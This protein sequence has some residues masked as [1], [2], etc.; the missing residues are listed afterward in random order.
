LLKRKL[1][2]VAG[3]AFAA[4]LVL[5][6]AT[7]G[8]A[9]ATTHRVTNDTMR[10]GF[11]PSA[12]A[13]DAHWYR[14]ES[15]VGGQVSLYKTGDD[16]DDDGL[17]APGDALGNG[18][19]AFTTNGSSSSKAQIVTLQH[20][21]NVNLSTIGAIGYSTLQSPNNTNPAVVPA[22]QIQIDTDG[23]IGGPGFTTLVYEPANNADNQGPIQ[24]NTWQ[25]WDATAGHWWTTRKITCGAFELDPGGGGPPFATPAEIAAGCP[26]AKVLALG[27]DVGTGPTNTVTAAD[28]LHIDI[29]ADTFT[30]DFG[31][32]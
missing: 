12:T 14:W 7:P 1:Q 2:Y 18:A 13:D 9:A 25:D 6:P 21:Y 26:N 28:G 27:L 20:V 19:A 5:G 24:S 4:A 30:W 29:G 16:I 31:P 22:I 17:T 11:P 10:D 8:F 23:T 3:A 15:T 32:K